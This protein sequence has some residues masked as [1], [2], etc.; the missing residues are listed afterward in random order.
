MSPPAKNDHWKI[1]PSLLW[2]GCI[3]QFQK[4]HSSD[5]GA[6]DALSKCL[7]IEPDH[8]IR[9]LSLTT[10]RGEKRALFIMCEQQGKTSRTGKR[11]IQ[12][13]GFAV[14]CLLILDLVFLTRLVGWRS[15][16][17]PTSQAKEMDGDT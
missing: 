10:D 1:R 8:T 11:A 6:F 13:A 12:L 14:E 15:L 5:V 2:I 17:I 16:I 9:E 4:N 3:L 7:E